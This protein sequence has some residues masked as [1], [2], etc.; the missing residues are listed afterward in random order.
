MYEIYPVVHTH[1]NGW[2]IG[3]WDVTDELHRPEKKELC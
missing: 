1:D 3:I 2:Y